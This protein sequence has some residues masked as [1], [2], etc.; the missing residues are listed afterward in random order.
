[1]ENP[2]ALLGGDAGCLF[3]GEGVTVNNI[4]EGRKLMKFHS[5]GLF[6]SSWDPRQDWN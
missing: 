4:S 3:L 1:M 5:F 6:K 2:F